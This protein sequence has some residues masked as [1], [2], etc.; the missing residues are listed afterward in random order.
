MTFILCWYVI[1]LFVKCGIIL[2]FDTGLQGRT[3]SLIGYTLYKF[4]WNEKNISDIWPSI[5]A[6]YRL[7]LFNTVR[8]RQCGRLFPDDIFKRI[9][10]NENVWILLKVS[11]KVVPMVRNNNIPALVQIMAWRRLGVNNHEA[12]DLRRHRA[13][14]DVIVMRD[15]FEQVRCC[16]Y[17]C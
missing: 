8:P 3:V 14:Y 12:G 9:F 10:L 5:N 15:M 7:W 17:V 16:W 2:C 1:C 4:I 13:Y 11:L 6:C